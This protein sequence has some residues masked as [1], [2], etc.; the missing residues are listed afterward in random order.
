MS[1]QR[2]LEEK[3]RVVC[4]TS[5]AHHICSGRDANGKM[6]HWEFN[7]YFGPTFTDAKGNIL[8]R[9]PMREN[10]PAWKPFETW[11]GDSLNRRQSLQNTSQPRSRLQTL[12]GPST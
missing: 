9:Q 5:N 6:W 10:H 12:R 2:P 8:K 7:S 11:L 4:I 3:V 1:D